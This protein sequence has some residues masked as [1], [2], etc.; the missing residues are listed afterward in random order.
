MKIFR[1]EDF[2]N[3]WNRL[4]A[5]LPPFQKELEEV[6]IKSKPVLHPSSQDI[7]N[8]TLAAQSLMF[9]ADVPGFEPH[10]LQ[11][12]L[13]PVPPDRK[14]DYHK[15]IAKRYLRAICRLYMVDFLCLGYALPGDCDSLY[16]EVDE[17]LLLEGD[18]S[19]RL[20]AK[21]MTEAKRWEKYNQ[22][23][24]TM[25]LLTAFFLC[26]LFGSFLVLI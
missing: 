24:V 3:E 4:A 22:R 26:I 10:K 19:V 18:P 13:L 5:I 21:K 17:A 7:L 14:L 12:R 11:K 16:G 1:F 23:I 2:D 20:I 9:Y 25:V 8:T 15:R 6:N